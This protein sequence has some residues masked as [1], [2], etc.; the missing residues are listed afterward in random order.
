MQLEPEQPVVV[1]LNS[2]AELIPDSFQST[3]A[4]CAQAAVAWVSLWNGKR[5]GV[6]QALGS[7]EAPE[8][9]ARDSR[10]LTLV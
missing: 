1:N 7:W 6:P 10:A 3:R 5:W 4:T 2:S 8:P 9:L